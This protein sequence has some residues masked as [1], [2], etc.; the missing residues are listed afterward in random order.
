MNKHD[1]LLSVHGSIK[2]FVGV[3][4]SGL[5]IMGGEICFAQPPDVDFPIDK[6]KAEQEMY[7]AEWAQYLQE[8]EEMF[9]QAEKL[10]LPPARL[11]AVW[12][13]F[14]EAFAQN[15]PFSEEDERL[16][17]MATERLAYWEGGEGTTATPQEA[18]KFADEPPDVCFGRLE[19]AEQSSVSG[20]R[21]LGRVFLD[22]EVLEPV[23]IRKNAAGYS[24]RQCSAG[25]PN[26][27]K[28]AEA[29]L[30]FFNNAL[31]ARFGEEKTGTL[32]TY[33]EVPGLGY[34]LSGETEITFRGPG[35][36]LEARRLGDDYVEVTLSPKVR[37]TI[38][39]VATRTALGL[40]DSKA[41]EESWGDQPEDSRIEREIIWWELARPEANPNNLRI[42]R[43]VGSFEDLGNLL[44]TGETAGAKTDWSSVLASAD[45][46]VILTQATLSL[47]IV[48]QPE[49]IGLAEAMLEL[50]IST[51][52]G[53]EFDVG[54]LEDR[55]GKKAQL[56]LEKVGSLRGRYLPLVRLYDLAAIMPDRIAGK[57]RR[58][59]YQ[60]PYAGAV[61]TGFKRDYVTLAT[62]PR[63]FQV[64]NALYQ[65]QAA[66][67]ARTMGFL[68]CLLENGAEGPSRLKVLK[69]GLERLNIPPES[70]EGM[71]VSQAFRYL[72]QGFS[73][74]EDLRAGQRSFL[75]SISHSEPE[76]L[77]LV[78][79]LQSYFDT[80]SLAPTPSCEV[81]LIPDSF[82]LGPPFYEPLIVVPGMPTPKSAQ[83]GRAHV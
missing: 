35:S 41:W 60:L 59:Y 79:L 1:I 51:N 71:D 53:V 25:R 38:L 48:E 56:R 5:L 62:A 36:M 37:V 73:L 44:V 29:D 21:R 83:I 76:V 11:V 68:G 27:I 82:L 77:T 54:S 20:A 50:A 45:L 65:D 28:V 18:P 10:V 46:E 9:G 72:F 17:K 8:M 66:E 75:R 67:M 30:E 74:P 7:K 31:V 58:N 80:T 70:L 2:V 34:A 52:S 69:K 40:V 12:I 47:F 32:K 23:L 22:E 13:D 19:S 33:H 64:A 14:L 43:A 3:L 42:H 16:R 15:D 6:Y 63:A 26:E 39:L 24:F 81:A 55:W 57:I 61:G 49:H 78:R 4:V